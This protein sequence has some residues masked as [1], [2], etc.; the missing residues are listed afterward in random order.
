MKW[1]AT[2]LRL[3]LFVALASAP[4]PRAA[5]EE[6]GA[7]A[8]LEGLHA[9]LLDVMQHADALGFEGRRARLA[10]VLTKSFD[11]ASMARIAAGRHWSELGDADR[12]RLVETFSNLTIATYAARFTGYSGER[13]EITGEAPSAQQTT[14]V[15]TRIVRPGAEEVKLDYRLRSSAAGW[16]ILDVFLDGSVSELALRRSE[17]TAVIQRDG[18]QALVSALD[19]KIADYAAGKIEPAS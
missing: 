14:V 16:R 19:R 15:H 9:A 1:N 7:R 17:Y 10:P 11:L 6:S 8:V 12:Q 3:A 2:I 4:T 13:F 18:F 5:A